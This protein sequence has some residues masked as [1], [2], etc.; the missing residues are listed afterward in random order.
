MMIR[1]I[2]LCLMVTSAAACL[3]D[4]GAPRNLRRISVLS[5]IDR[6]DTIDARP[7]KPILIQ[8]SDSTGSLSDTVTV[9]IKGIPTGMLDGSLGMYLLDEFGNPTG[10]I[11]LTLRAFYD[12]PS[13]DIWRVH[14][15]GT[16]LARLVTAGV[17]GSPLRTSPSPSPDGTRLAYVEG[18]ATTA[19]YV[20]ILDLQ[21]GSTLTIPAP[22]AAEIRWSPTADRIAVKSGAGSL[23]VMNADGSQLTQ[24]APPTSY[25]IGLDWSRDGRWIVAN[26]GGVP[27]ILKPTTMGLRLPLSIPGVGDSWSPQ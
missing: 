25:F 26:L 2:V 23:Y 14:P 18:D 1:W 21:S 6:A 9:S 15:D 4:I 7:T 19:N 5:D 10:D 3:V 22:G 16:G 20:R 8:I 24:L 12:P 17:A 11:T 27:T 13:G